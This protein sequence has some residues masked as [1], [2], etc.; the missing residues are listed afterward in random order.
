MSF[1]ILGL[2]YVITDNFIVIFLD[3]TLSL[4]YLGIFLYGILLS[5]VCVQ[6]EHFPFLVPSQAVRKCQDCH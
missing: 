2:I 3:V 4:Y 6:K 1:H 5:G